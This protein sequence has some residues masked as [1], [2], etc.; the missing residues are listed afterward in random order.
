MKNYNKYK[1]N[2][3]IL[4]SIFLTLIIFSSCTINKINSNIQLTSRTGFFLGTV[5]TIKLYD[6]KNTE[7]ILDL[8]FDKIKEIEKKMTINAENSEVIKINSFAGKNFV[9]VSNDT[10]YVIKKGKSYSQLSKGRFDISIGPIVKLWN[11]G[12]E[13]ARV[14]SQSEINS[15][16]DLVNYNDII[17][18]ESKKSIMLK[19]EG[20]IL[21]LGGIAKGYA[22]DTIVEILKKHNIKS[23]IIDL[24]GNIFAYGNKPDGSKW[25][26]AIQNPFS[27]RGNYIGIV[28][29]KNK[30]VV[31]SGIY[32]RFLEKNGKR[33]HHI[34]DPKTGYPVENNL[35]SVSII[36]DKSIDADSLS[37]SAF[38]LGLEKGLDFI[39][40]IK[41]T[42]AIFV[43][44]NS[45]IYITS[46]LKNNFKLSNNEF[47][48]MN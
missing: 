2:F 45:K 25:N 14:P 1:K 38:A 29:V 48:L 19:K 30:A 4:L 10:F 7:N 37:T 41:N 15:K 11:I 13:N 6:N 16:L 35:A 20:M 12:T 46:G 47:N 26:I 36:A 27:S 17:L 8:A 21:D 43:T 39:E 28:S 3:M 32:E 33:Y 24:G 42:E 34:L 44:K 9:K 40:H 22:A 23:A 18:D 31:T 5:V